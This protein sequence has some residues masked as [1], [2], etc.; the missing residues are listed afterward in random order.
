MEMTEHPTKQYFN[1]GDGDLGGYGGMGGNGLFTILLLFFLFSGGAGGFGGWGNRNAL[2]ADLATS[3]AESVAENRAGLNYLGQTAA[4]QGAKLDNILMG[5]STNTAAIQNSLCAGFNG[6]NTA[7]LNSRYDVTRA[8]E[9]CCCQTQQNIAALNANLDKATCAIITSNKD[10]T[11]S[12]LT[13]LCNHW[14][15]E[16]NRRICKL[17]QELNAKNIIDALKNA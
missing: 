14:S 13:A 7:I 17:E 6:L 8:I 10:N 3:T 12:I 9:Q 15:D 11:Q 5:M 4:A 1:F 2:G 16:A